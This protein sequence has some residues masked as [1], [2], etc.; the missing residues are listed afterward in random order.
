M[1]NTLYLECFSGISGDMTVAALLDLGANIEKLNHAL[2][3]LALDG[4][5][6]EIKRVKKS[7]IDA[8]D[9]HVILESKYENHDH[10]MAYLYGNQVQNQDNHVHVHQNNEH[11]NQENEH[12]HQENH[13]HIEENKA[14]HQHESVK[15]EKHHEHEHRT[16]SAILSIIN[17]ADMTK[18]AKEIATRIFKVLGEAEAKAHG[19]TIERVH[20]HEVGAVDSIVDIVAV[21]V[22]LDDLEV[23]E[24]IVP[25]LYEG[26]GV[27]RCQHGIMP[28]PVPAVTNIAL[29]HGL[30]LS[31]TETKGE[32]VTPTGAAIVAAIK[33]SNQLPSEFRVKKVG[34]GA[35]KRNYERP[36][37]L[38]AML[39]D[40][41]TKVQDFIV[42]MESNVDDC[43]GEQL[44]FAMERLLKAGALDVSY[45]P[46][47]MKK[48]RPAYQLTVICK[49]EEVNEIEQVIFRETTTI[50][51]RKIRMERSILKREIKRIDTS[52]GEVVVKICE[53]KEGK[54]YYPE[55]SSI[56]EICK[57]HDIAFAD[58][59]QKI[60]SEL[61]KE[62]Y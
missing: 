39:L 44:G 26:Q 27:V 7:G 42:K 51:I 50:G 23:N 14:S 6:T 36:S 43:S 56:V 33:T 3:T 5:Q 22:C 15:Q 59:Y 45:T 2:S 35:G 25:V 1:G 60:V 4:F 21:A 12:S 52:F 9:F 10:D 61:Q 28:I 20:F 53:L 57:T 38:R 24:V 54:R 46:I 41:N 16:L 48:N 47:F 17:Q 8:C 32:L 40:S 58:A 34:I 30:T 62:L 49:E 31:I 37:M 18:Q 11:Q 19:T 55:Y 13:T 29:A